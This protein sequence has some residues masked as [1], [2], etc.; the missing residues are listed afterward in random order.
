MERSD[1]SSRWAAAVALA[2]LAVV[3][4]CLRFPQL[5]EWLGVLHMRPYFLDLVAVLAACDARAQGLDP[6]SIPSPFDPLGR[7]HVYGPWWLELRR[8]GLT[9]VDAP[10]LGGLLCAATVGVLAWG[11]R[12]RGWAQ[13]LAVF[14]LLISPPLLLGY[15]RGNNDLV[16]VLML[17]AGAWAG[18]GNGALVFQSGIIWLAACLKFYPLAA[19]PLL[20]TGRGRV[21]AIGAA[22]LV[23][24]AFAAAW[25]MGRDEYR[26]VMSLVPRPDTW[27]GFGLAA[28]PL[29]FKAVVGVGD[30][31]V[32]VV[33]LFAGVAAVIRAGGFDGEALRRMT[34]EGA[35]GRWL[36]AGGATWAGCFFLNTNFPYRV[37]LLVMAAAAW[38]ALWRDEGAH[39]KTRR[40][41]RNLILLLLVMTWARV[42]RI[43]WVFAVPGGG[44]KQIGVASFGVEHGLALGLTCVIIAALTVW[45]WAWLRGGNQVSGPTTAPAQGRGGASSA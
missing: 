39:G 44:N 36:I 5:W 24:A 37:A 33:G 2:A 12:P 17:A 4:A 29:V 14:A 25:W 15:E 34:I 28:I 20:A 26:L 7:P 31:V 42:F 18:A 16:I 40:V 3:V 30:K 35:P 19:L 43:L 13:G 45:A 41:G 10:W 32:F 21:R 9:R 11:L 8:L 27:Y 38:T 23:V 22:V 1:T 6:Y